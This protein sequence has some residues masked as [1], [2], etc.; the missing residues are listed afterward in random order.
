MRGCN[1]AEQTE[2]KGSCSVLWRNSAGVKAEAA[3]GHE[4]VGKTGQH[5]V[6]KKGR[7]GGDVN[8]LLVRGHITGREFGQGGPYCPGQEKGRIFRCYSPLQRVVVSLLKS[9]GSCSLYGG[10]ELRRTETDP[11]TAMAGLGPLP[12]RRDQ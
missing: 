1:K 12:K 6:G 11:A 2:K 5:W 7:E 10:A 9:T 8:G 4:A 3:R